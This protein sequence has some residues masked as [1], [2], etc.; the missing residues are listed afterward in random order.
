MPST[1]RGPDQIII[2]RSEYNILYVDKQGVANK[3][4]K[5]KRWDIKNHFIK[6]KSSS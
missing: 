6:R 1:F 2:H 3:V 4:F 5:C